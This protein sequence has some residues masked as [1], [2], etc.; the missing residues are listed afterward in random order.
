[1]NNLVKNY[2]DE[3][4]TDSILYE[5]L[6]K[7]TDSVLNLKTTSEKLSN[8]SGMTRAT[9][10]ERLQDTAYRFFSVIDAIE[11][12][13]CIK[14]FS[15]RWKTLNKFGQSLYNFQIEDYFEKT[16]QEIAAR[17][18]QLAD[19]LLECGITDKKTWDSGKPNRTIQTFIIN[20]QEYYFDMIKTPVFN[21]LGF[22]KELV[23]IGR[24]ITKTILESRKSRVCMSALNS[25][26]DSILILDKD[27]KI[28]FCNTAFL[29]TF[30]FTSTELLESTLLSDIC[31]PV[32]IHY[33]QTKWEKLHNNISWIGDFDGIIN[34]QSV[35][36]HE[37]ILPVM[38]GHTYPIFYIY[39]IRKLS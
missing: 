19:S 29:K 27:T 15:G 5:N 24:D 7:L 8:K 12:L 39:L 23:I 18:P 6:A 3:N 30:N 2:T 31:Q 28:M 21:H 34:N 35:S 37:E 22:P 25:A 33:E 16:D 32:D 10:K 11:D 20:D 14:D 9:L 36:C 26:S 38:N 17:F 13:V 4:L 1:M